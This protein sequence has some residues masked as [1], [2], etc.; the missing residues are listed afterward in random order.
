MFCEL[1]ATDIKTRRYDYLV[2]GVERTFY[3]KIYKK[4][5]LALKMSSGIIISCL[6]CA[7]TLLLYFC[8]IARI[9]IVVVYHAYCMQ[10]LV[11]FYLVRHFALLLYTCMFLYLRLLEM[12]F[13]IS[14]RLE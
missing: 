8:C 4:C 6:R 1:L 14:I 10:I 13:Y 7:V 3:K 9:L 2:Y 11:I 5:L 12:L